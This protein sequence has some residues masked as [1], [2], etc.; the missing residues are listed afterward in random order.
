MPYYRLFVANIV[1]SRDKAPRSIVPELARE[2]SKPSASG[3]ISSPQSTVRLRAA[4]EDPSLRAGNGYLLRNPIGT[5]QLA[6]A[7]EGADLSDRI[8]AAGKDAALALVRN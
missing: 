5:L 1:T 2:Q 3:R 7:V 8:L 4:A 6:R